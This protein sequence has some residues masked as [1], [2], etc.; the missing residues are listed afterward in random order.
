MFRPD[1]S[2]TALC[3]YVDPAATVVIAVVVSI[4]ASQLSG[5]T[6][7]RSRSFYGLLVRRG[8]N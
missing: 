6:Y 4:S 1:G 2:N 7:N 3:R 5:R 8:L